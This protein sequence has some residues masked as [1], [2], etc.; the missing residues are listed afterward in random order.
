MGIQEESRPRVF[1]STWEGDYY[2]RLV[3]AYLCACNGGGGNLGKD[4]YFVLRSFN[5]S[6]NNRKEGRGT[7]NYAEHDIFIANSNRARLCHWA[8]K[9]GRPAL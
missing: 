4:F 8:Q 7:E 1:W 6:E 9:V 5:D 2:L 3:F